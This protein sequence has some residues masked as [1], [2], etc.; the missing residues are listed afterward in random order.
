[1]RLSIGEPWP[2]TASLPRGPSFQTRPIDSAG[3][4]IGLDAARSPS[5]LRGP[6]FRP[7]AGV[8]ASRNCSSQDRC[9]F[10]FGRFLRPIENMAAPAALRH[11][12]DRHTTGLR[13]S[14]EN[15]SVCRTEAGWLLEME[16]DA[17]GAVAVVIRSRAGR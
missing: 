7:A 6:A 15:A 16:G 8:V 17:I 12:S 10:V 13:D 2:E 1:M 4:E 5:R 11:T 14:H 9:R 3:D